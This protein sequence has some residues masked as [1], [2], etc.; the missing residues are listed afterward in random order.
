MKRQ[1]FD[2]TVVGA[3]GEDLD[4]V[5]QREGVDTVAVPLLRDPHPT[6]DAVSLLRLT[7][8]LRRLRPDIVNAGTPKGGLLGLMAA[9]AIRTPIRI[10]LLRG[11][12]LETARGALRAV[13]TATERLAASCAHDV[14]C[15]SPSLLRVS[16][17]GGYV[18]RAKATVLGAG[19]S[20]GVDVDHYQRSEE[21]RLAGHSQAAALGIG[22]D[23]PV[24]GFV[25]RL[26]VDKGIV[27]LLEA[28]SLVVREIPEAKLLLVGGDLAGETLDASLLER[29]RSTR[30]VFATKTIR[31]L[32]PLYA[33]MDVLGFPSYREG[34]PNV[35]LEAASAEVPTVG[36]RSTGVI[37][38][39]IDGETGILV[40][41]RDVRALAAAILSYLRSEPSRRAHGAAARARAR[42][43]FDRRIVWNTWLE[44]YRSRLAERGL[45]QP[46]A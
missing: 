21:L 39:V 12:R 1:G 10:Y 2:V 46:V 23:A 19:S 30:G 18:P 45:P 16:V 41:Q 14:I 35:V 26:A 42:R 22:S 38:A 15:V 44:V 32:R 7:N 13:L 28:F 20:N 40:P 31:D 4:R 29:V 24:I 36:F 9:R 43:L 3:P 11:L 5:G 8:A 17:D 37:D 33:R 27:E 34:F 25:G 6:R